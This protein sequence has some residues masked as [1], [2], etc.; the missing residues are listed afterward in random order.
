MAVIPDKMWED[1]LDTK[2][3]SHFKEVGDDGEATFEQVIDDSEDIS[4]EIFNDG[5]YIF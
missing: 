1:F 3:K 4:K 2:Q 5:E